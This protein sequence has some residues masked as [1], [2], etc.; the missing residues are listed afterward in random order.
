MLQMILN[1]MWQTYRL[2][3]SGLRDRLSMNLRMLLDENFWT[4]HFWLV[5]K[6][7]ERTYQQLS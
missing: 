3:M 4:D 7:K 6:A 2:A 1:K 5:L